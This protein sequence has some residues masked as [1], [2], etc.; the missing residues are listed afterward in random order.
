MR[1]G[2]SLVKR[3]RWVPIVFA[4]PKG[5]VAEHCSY[6]RRRMGVGHGLGR[7]DG[8]GEGWL[9]RLGL[10]RRRVVVLFSHISN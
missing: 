2:R 1:G 5:H 9:R 8:D 4:E 6:T 10:R 3:R 7:L